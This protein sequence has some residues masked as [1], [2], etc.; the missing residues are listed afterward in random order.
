MY[1]EPRFSLARALSSATTTNFGP[2]CL[3]VDGWGG[4]LKVLVPGGSGGNETRETPLP[5]CL[6]LARVD[7][8]GAALDMIDE[9]RRAL[10]QTRSFDFVMGWV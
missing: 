2:S 8:R 9:W 3:S 7:R 4:P 5:L 10:V 6:V 1:I